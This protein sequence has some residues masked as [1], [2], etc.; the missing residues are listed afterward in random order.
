MSRSSRYAGS[1]PHYYEQYLA[2]VLFE[3]YAQDL[4]HRIPDRAEQVLELACGT[5]RL[6]RQLLSKL[7]PSG[8]IIATDLHEDML[9][10]ASAR[11]HDPRIRWKKADATHLP[12]DAFSFDLVACQFGVM[13][14]PDQEKAYRE[15]FRVLRPG[16]A[17]W[18][19]TWDS[20]N[21]NPRAAVIGKVL[22][23]VIGP[24]NH[25]FWK[26]GPYS[27]HDE[28]RIR[29]ELQA[30]GFKTIQLEQLALEAAF[31]TAENFLTGFIEGS[32]LGPFLRAQ[33]SDV[34]AA[35]R[36]KLAREMAALDRELENRVPMQ[37]FVVEALKSA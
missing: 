33:P 26:K 37:A 2:P 36:H 3:P 35:I 28:T 8:Q 25:G 18:F 15:V 27:Y 10:I 7:A 32:T 1:I 14:F 4:A 11:V 13:F 30:A 12:F 23:E 34:E 31:D 24:D 16:G 21:R 6:T 9:N 22:D 20:P 29:K 5:G 19:N 17:F